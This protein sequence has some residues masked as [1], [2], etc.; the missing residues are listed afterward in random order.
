VT[1]PPR[2]ELERLAAGAPSDDATRAHVAACPSCSEQ[3]AAIERDNALLA[4]FVE[5]NRDRVA[6][7]PGLAVG[8]TPDGY[9]V[10]EEIHRGS[11]GVVYRAVQTATKRVVALKVMLQG[12]FAT[13]RQRKRFEREVELVAS[14]RH[15]GIVTVFDSGVDGEGRHYLAM[16]HVDGV[17]LDRWDGPGGRGR[18]PADV[19]AVLALFGRIADAVAAA[20]RRGIIHRDLKP[21]NIL[22]DESG[23]PHVLDFGLAKIVGPEEMGEAV[24][25]TMAGEFLGTFAYAAPEQVAGDPALVDTRTDVHALGVILYEMLTGERP[26]RLAG[27]VRDVVRTI[28]EGE[29]RR[30][31]TVRPD[32]DD[33]L[34]AILL[35]AL[36]REPDRRY[37]SVQAMHDDVRRYLGGEPISVKRDRTLY[38]VGKAL[39]RHRGPVA[40]GAAAL[41]V[42]VGF[43]ITMWFMFLAKLE[44]SRRTLR[45]MESLVGVISATDQENP[46]DPLAASSIVDL[47]DRTSAIVEEDLADL[48]DVAAAVRRSLGLAY[49]SLSAYEESERHLVSVLDSYERRRSPPDADLARALHDLGRLRWKT[50]RYAEAEVLY[51]RGLDMRRALHPEGGPELARTM[52]H[53]A[54]TLRYQGRLR[55]SEQWFRAAL[56]MRRD[57]FGP[58]HPEVANNRN[59]LGNCLFDMERYDEALAQYRDSL[60]II[61]GARDFRTARLDQN[62]G[63]CLI[64]LG[65]VEAA[66]RPLLESLAVKV[67]R[68]APPAAAAAVAAGYLGRVDG[69]VAEEEIEET[70]DV[71]A[72]VQAFARLA[73][74]RGALDRAEARARRALEVRRRVH[75]GDHPMVAESLTL[76]ATIL[77]AR[78][79]PSEARILA[80]EAVEM[81]QRGHGG[82]HWKPALP[83]IALARCLA[84]EGRG[85]EAERRLASAAARLAEALGDDAPST[86]EAQRRLEEVRAAIAA[87]GPGP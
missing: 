62:I 8:A 12:A 48:P 72:T 53:L 73:L 18:G 17:P 68:D 39:R 30:P 76:L 64:R 31:R 50:A 55:E 79:R 54:S 11:Q 44:E 26:Y 35:H 70:L 1:C 45:T 47:L 58:T 15:P 81:L 66:R 43:G 4:E 27:S 6:H 83:E 14:L 61:S 10:L 37:R 51:R 33:D 65:D 63:E 2:D 3:I 9:E 42:L 84:A 21:A 52:H 16:E 85:V 25:A 56:E 57:V 46:N 40:A 36:A 77:L 78:D 80:D 69:G 29:P 71:A 22:V 38:V 49:M 75:P 59:G 67:A 74:V 5:A 87:G 19:G 7:G 60:A 82:T 86:R 23:A 34:E 28:A 20:H 41:L 32:L 13:D 24:L